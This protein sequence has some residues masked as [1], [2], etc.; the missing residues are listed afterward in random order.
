LS[1]GRE[2]LVRQGHAH[3]SKWL[4]DRFSREIT[5]VTHP[6]RVPWGKAKRLTRFD[7][8]NAP[9]ITVRVELSYTASVVKSECAGN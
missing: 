9:Q 6:K 8:E 5:R 7:T 1:P 2:T 3:A 4:H